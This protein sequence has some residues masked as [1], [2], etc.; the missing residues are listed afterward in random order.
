M[1]RVLSFIMLAALL[2]LAACGGGGQAVTET[3]AETTTKAETV[4]ETETE[5]ET[6]TKEPE[7]EV[8]SMQL[9]PD[10][11]LET[12]MELITQKNHNNN[13]TFRTFAKRSFYN[14][15]VKSPRW[16][17]A[18]W[19]SGPDLKDCIID[20]EQNVITDGKYR[21][22]I[23]DP[24]E[25]MMTFHLDTSLY[26]DGKPAV[27]GDYWPHLLIEQGDFGAKELDKETREYYRCSSEN[28]ILSL[29]LKLG[30]YEKTEIEGDWVRAAQFLLY[31]YVKGI[32]TNDFCWFGIQLFDSRSDMNDNY[33]GYDGGK[34]DASGA[35]IFSIGS[36]YLYG[37]K[38]FFEY[39]KP[40]PNSDWIHIE[41]DIRPFLDKM[42]EYGR[43]DGYF[44]AGN[45]NKLIINGMN[46]GWETIGTFDHTMYVKNL[47]LTSYPEGR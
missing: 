12:G 30:D 26:Y 3:E 1:K 10:I 18:Q 33:I 16:R 22:F 44:K 4:T 7:K 27:V 9:I 32:N 46:M 45:I 20:S 29:D 17:L 14:T 36:K 19:D 31:F 38:S 5:T 25:N 41:I 6:E 47:T 8:K 21:T 40:V 39:G 28:I 11:K 23:Y 37:D 15:K 13:D 43:N 24:E 2:F 35:M 34:A 42:F